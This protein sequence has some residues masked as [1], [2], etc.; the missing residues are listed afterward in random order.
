M[1]F[2]DKQFLGDRDAGDVVK[3]SSR[4]CTR[5]LPFQEAI[6]PCMQG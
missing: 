3:K 1:L 4:R 6:P 2:N 5:V